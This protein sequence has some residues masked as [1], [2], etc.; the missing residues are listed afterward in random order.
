[1]YIRQTILFPLILATILAVLTFWISHAVDINGPKMNGSNRHDYDYILNNFYTTKTDVNGNLHYVV[2]ATEMEHFP[3]DDST[4]LKLPRFVI[5]NINK[6]YTQISGLRGYV[7]SNGEVIKIVDNVKV[8]RSAFA[9]RGEMDMLTK[10]LTLYPDEEIA[11]TDSPV[12]IKQFPKT[13]IHA[14]GMFLN[15]K[16][17]TLTLGRQ[18][19][20]A[21]APARVYVHYEKPLDQLKTRASKKQKNTSK[22]ISTKNIPL[23]KTFQSPTINGTNK[24]RSENL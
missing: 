15:K 11:K 23:S 19:N 21:I 13:E 18:N 20:K 16:E 8:V 4:V 5:Y 2:T 17:Q 12:V 22:R 6:P 3:D 10:E 7:S 1:M 14:T 24:A 9:G